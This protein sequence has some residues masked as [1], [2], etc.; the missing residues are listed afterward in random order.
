MTEGSAR[1]SAQS[2]PPAPAS[3]Q[4]PPRVLLDRFVGA[5]A[6]AP[7]W[8]G[9]LTYVIGLLDI[10][11]GSLHT[12]RVRLHQVTAVLPGGL[13]DAAAAATVV[14]G[15]FLVL[16]AHSLRRRKHR[17][18]V[19]VVTLM[20]SS[21]LFHLLHGFLHEP[22]A[23]GLSLVGLTLLVGYRAQFYA[24]GDPATRIRA[25]WVFLVLLAAS[26][27]VGTTVIL[28]NVHAVV[29]GRPGVGPVLWYVLQGMVGVEGSLVFNEAHHRLEDVVG[30]L[31][32]GLGLM[33]SLTTAY[34][35]L[36]SPRRR[37]GLSDADDARVRELL[38]QHPDSLG[39]F[40]TRRDKEVIWSESGK[41][42]DRLPGR[43]RRHAR[44]PATPSETRR[45]GPGRS[46]RSSPR[47]TATRWTPA[48]LGCSERAGDDVD[49]RDRVRRPR[50]GRRGGRRRAGVHPRGP[51]DA[52]RAPDGEPDPRAR[53]TR[54]RSS[55]RGQASEAQ[56]RQRDGRRRRV[57][58]Q[59]DRARVLD[60]LGAGR[61]PRR[62]RRRHRHGD[63]GRRRA[64]VPAVR[65]LGARRD[66]ARRH[67]A[68]PRR[69]T[70]GSTR[71]SSSTRWP[72][73]RRSASSACRS[74][75][76]CSARPWSGASGSAP[77]RCCVAG[78]R[79]L[80]FASRW[81]Q[82]ESLYRFNAKFQPQWYRA[83]MRLPEHAARPPSRGPGRAG[84]GGIHRLAPAR[85]FGGRA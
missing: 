77:A 34:L 85:W 64:R 37:A 31:N 29:G 12:W 48:V 61:R 17:A 41:A 68:R 16:L 84:G 22:M 79:V 7:R 59:R 67:A 21:V 5:G 71:C 60:G 44:R 56:R 20:S 3:P 32:F 23:L 18:W 36:R 19:A 74:T 45:R 26:L 43:G 33:T 53:A 72:A 66:V 42:G 49:P 47:R 8:I 78:G 62:P 27:V 25:V 58:R 70:R 14:S 13:T 15:I 55:A 9:T 76:R 57:A 28:A 24:L 39:Y 51:P 73:P 40:T 65:P 69:P 6:R 83:Y 11:T 4:G 75:S 2:T 35:A 54:R 10:L 80:V 82:I 38:E 81:F 46:R 30:A 1:P 50:A 52:Q 63:P